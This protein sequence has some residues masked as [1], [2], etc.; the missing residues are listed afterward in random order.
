MNKNIRRMYSFMAIPMMVNLTAPTSNVVLP[1]GENSPL[2]V[3][4]EHKP[5][6]SEI[7]ETLNELAADIEYANNNFM[8]LRQVQI[9]KDYEQKVEE[10]RIK[11]E[12]RIREEQEEAE[13]QRILAEQEALRKERERVQNVHFNSYNIGSPSGITYEEMYGV[14][15]SSHYSNFLELANAFVDAERQYSVNAFAL[16]AIAGLESGWNTSNR[17]RNGSN[18]LTGMAV[19]HDGSAGTHYNSKYDCIMDL[20]RQLRTYY[21]NEGAVY[22]NGTS[23]SQ[24]NKRY[25]ASDSWYKKVDAIGD[26]LIKIYSSM[27]RS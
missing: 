22:Y 15:S 13:R 9:H 6:N 21:L 10:E 14:L 18:N 5:I 23:T 8:S 2:Y 11:E 4:Q 16:C 25:S 19:Y 1:T 17:A 12:Q 20:A 26:E 7:E 27:Y 3:V 24:V